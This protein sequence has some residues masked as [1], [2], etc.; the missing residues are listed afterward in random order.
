MYKNMTS[1]ICGA[2]MCRDFLRRD[3]FYT[4]NS[5]IGPADRVRLYACG[6]IIRVIIFDK[7]AQERKKLCL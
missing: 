5:I 2:V 1:Y 3:N 7:S 4:S 6:M